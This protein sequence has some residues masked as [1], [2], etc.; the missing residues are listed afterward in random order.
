MTGALS[1]PVGSTDNKELQQLLM[2]LTDA[3]ICY[4]F[5]HNP[6]PSPPFVHLNHFLGAFAQ[7]QKATINFVMSVSVSVHLLG[8]TWLSLDTFL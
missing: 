5:T 3:T 2:S 4:W 7:L 8:T 6:D 1:I